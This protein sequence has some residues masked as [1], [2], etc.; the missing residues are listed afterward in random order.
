[1]FDESNV[2][3]NPLATL[4]PKNEPRKYTLAEYLKR[5]EKSEEL[6]EY[7]DG[8]ISKL[9]MAREPHN[10]IIMNVGYALKNAIKANGQKYRVLGGQQ[11]VYLPA[12]NFGVYP[13]VIVVTETPK[14]W[15]NNKVLLIN[16]IVIIEV[17]SRSTQKNDRNSKFT[18]YK[19]LESFKEYVLIDQNK[20]YVETHFR[21]KPN[22]WKGT[23]YNDLNASIYLQSLD[24]HISLVDIYENITDI[25]QLKN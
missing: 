25:T 3:L 8:I 17:L 1:M 7:Y 11:K 24:C 6:L 10:E 2:A 14:Y 13:D 18:D 9:P 19:T 4:K 20:C 23:D 16:P 15:D 22:V 5:S 21:E 12:L